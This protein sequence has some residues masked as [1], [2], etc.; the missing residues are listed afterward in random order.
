MRIRS[1]TFRYERDRNRAKRIRRDHV[2]INLIESGRIVGDIAARKFAAGPGAA[3]VSRLATPMNI[4]L[5]E[6]E[7]LALI[8]PRAVL[9]R[10]MAWQPAL[11]GRACAPETAQAVILGG[12]LQSLDKLPQRLPLRDIACAE[13][14]SLALL[15]TC[16]GGSAPTPRLGDAIKIDQAT[17][18]RR[19]IATRLADPELD[20]DL[21]CREFDISRSRL[22]RVMG[23]RADIASV[24]R[25]MRLGAIQRDIVSNRFP[26]LALAEIGR[27][28]GLV[29]ERNFR[30]AF[31]HEFGYPPS[32]LRR[33][34]Q[35]DATSNV[36][37]FATIGADIERW[38]LGISS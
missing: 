31:V 23:E 2:M 35:G 6:A 12:L 10:H 24:I 32:D 1:G 22:Y 14:S 38:L 3:L 5:E 29:D 17:S 25:R 20:V 11:D 33:Q 21:I 19:F 16:L 37:D 13:R 15:A 7:W 26:E 30:R 8:V 28:W 36:A 34:A 4:V 18:I 9:D 27:R